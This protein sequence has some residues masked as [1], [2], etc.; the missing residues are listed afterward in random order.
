MLIING[1]YGE[2]GGQILRT[3]L[4]LA[5]IQS[6]PIRIENIRAGRKNPG[7]A[8]QHLTAVRAAAMICDANLAGD[9]LGSTTL[10]FEPRSQTIP[11]IYEF[12]VSE[13]R[14]GGSAGAATLVL[15]TVLPPLALAAEPS[16]VIVKGGTHV[17]WSPSFHYIRDVYLPMA[18]HLGLPATVELLAWG[19]YPAGEGTI[20]A[21]L[22]GQPWPTSGLTETRGVLKQIKGVAV[23]SSLPAHIAQRM[24][25][26]AANLLE[27]ASLPFTIEPQ[28]VR[29]ASPG[30]GIFLV[31]EYEHSLAGFTA[32]GEIGKP[33][34]RVAEEAINDLT[35]FHHS[36]ALLDKHLADQLILPQALSGRAATL[37]VERVSNH[38]LTNL[39]LVEQFL[40]PVAEINRDEGIIQFTQKDKVVV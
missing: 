40:G 6:R 3:S 28:R 22:P 31:A 33:A 24:R 17:P 30:A 10:I 35:A 2:G 19:W 4:A 37:S 20:K 23:A 25:D 36:N 11:G 14:E 32:L 8:A 27:Q 18:A 7:L 15:Q 16:S 1:V 34:E 38:T 5:A 9:S 29:S 21:V 12:D 39:W 26:R 13:A